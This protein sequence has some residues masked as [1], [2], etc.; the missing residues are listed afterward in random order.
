MQV[1]GQ[2]NYTTGAGLRGDYDA[3][4]MAGLVECQLRRLGA[5]LIHGL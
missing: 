1:P 2:V 4:P 5:S 3:E